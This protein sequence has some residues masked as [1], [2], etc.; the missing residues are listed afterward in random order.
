M[1]YAHAN[2]KSINISVAGLQKWNI[3]SV[4]LSSDLLSLGRCSHSGLSDTT[5]PRSSSPLAMLQYSYAGR[6]RNVCPEMFANSMKVCSNKPVSTPRSV[7]EI[8]SKL[9]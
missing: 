3:S 4:C 9:R 8:P 6:N 5:K 2:A 7:E 1:D